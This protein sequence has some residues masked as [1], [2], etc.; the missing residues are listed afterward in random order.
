MTEKH[1]LTVVINV[2]DSERATN[3]R[4]FSPWVRQVLVFA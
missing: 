2:F 4:G 3:P 1:K